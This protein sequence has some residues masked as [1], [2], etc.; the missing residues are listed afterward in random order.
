[1][2]NPN[3][4]NTEQE[5]IMSHAKV[6]RNLHQ[7]L[8]QLDKL[9]TMLHNYTCPHCRAKLTLTKKGGLKLAA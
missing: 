5:Y 1:M 2:E 6:R 3:N 7:M 8:A 4:H 9:K